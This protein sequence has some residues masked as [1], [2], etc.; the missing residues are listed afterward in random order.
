[1]ASFPY[2]E[3]SSIQFYVLGSE[4]NANESHVTVTQQ[5]ASK[6]GL[7]SVRGVYDAHMGTTD[8]SWNCKTCEHDKK[9]CPGHYGSYQ[10]NIPVPSPM[11]MKDIVKW[12][13]VICFKC[14]KP[15]V[16]PNA[17]IAKLPK[18][19]ILSEYVKITRTANKNPSCVHCEE[20]HPHVVKDQSDCTSIYMEIYDDKQKGKLPKRIMLYP[21]FIAKIFQKIKHETV[22]LLGKPVACHPSK[23]M[24]STLRVS[25]NTIRPD[26]KKI[27]AG[28]SNSNDV[29]IL[30][31]T[32]MKIN[33]QIP[34]KL[35]AI[36]DNDLGM[37]I[38]NLCLAVFHMIRGSNSTS[39]RGLVSANKK[40]LTGIAK[41]W[42][43]KYGRIRRNLMGRRAN[44][45]GRSF[46]TGD[47]FMRV[48]QVGV[49][50]VIAKNIQHPVP[51]Q[52]YNYEQ[53]MTYFMNGNKRYPG[54]TKV[55]KLSTGV[56]HTINR[57]KDDFRLEI[58]DIIYRDTI[59][60][61]VVGFNRQPS[62]EPSSISS[63][64]CVVMEKSDTIRLNVT[65]CSLFN[66]DFDGDKTWCLQQ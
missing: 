44:H 30:M 55:K 9:L 46:I 65:S 15:I 28:R 21:H 18:D 57:I 7:P 20:I 26:V 11:F 1:M 3:I 43:R 36:I 50:L 25:P 42:P 51:V 23:F 49:P 66:A 63:M 13:K 37:Q 52:R 54:C 38:H 60:G 61:D 24:I 47:S 53:C 62:L 39:K 35:P 16:A 48:Y 8:Y 29:T 34:N 41:R 31:Q 10:L 12:L 22:A 56:T 14:G 17:N 19:K 45:M 2:S 64:E 4:D 27:N 6:G 59:D 32:I 58:G 5:D 33:E 40:P